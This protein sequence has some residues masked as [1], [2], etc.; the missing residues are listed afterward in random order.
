IKKIRLERIEKRKAY[1]KAKKEAKTKEEA[2]EDVLDKVPEIVRKKEDLEDI[3]SALGDLTGE[4]YGI[5]IDLD[6]E[7]EKTAEKPIFDYNEEDIGEFEETHPKKAIW[8]GKPTKLFKD[9]II[10]K[11]ES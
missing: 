1:K 3:M 10:K 6:T 4:T 9:W 7:E 8:R 2:Q 11:Q 5:S